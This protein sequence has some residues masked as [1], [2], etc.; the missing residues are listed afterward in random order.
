MPQ[1]FSPP[2]C[3]ATLL[4]Y[5]ADARAG[6]HIY[7]KAR[8][9]KHMDEFQSATRGKVHV[10]DPYHWMGED[11]P[12]VKERLNEFVDAQNDL[13]QKY[14]AENINMAHLE[15]AMYG[16]NM[17]AKHYAPAQYRDG[18]W[19]WFYNA[20][21]EPQTAFIRSKD[22]KLPNPSIPS[23][24][25]GEMFFDPMVL[26]EDGTASL[27]TFN[28]SDCGKYFAYGVSLS[29]GDFL[30]VFVRR[31]DCPLTKD[32]DMSNDCGRF[33]EEIKHVKF[34]D[35]MF[36]PDSKGIFYQRFPEKT[37][38]DGK[39]SPDLDAMIYYHSLG[40]DQSEDILVHSDPEN[41]GSLFY[42]SV[43]EDG[44]Y[45]VLSTVEDCGTENKLWVV[46]F[47][48]DNIGP[49]MPWIKLQDDWTTE[50]DFVCNVGTIFY[51]RTSESAP[52]NRLISIDIADKN[53][54][55]VEVIP[56]RDDAVLSKIE[57]INRHYFIATYKRNVMNELYVLT[58]TGELV[59]QVAEG[60][61]GTLTVVSLD[62]QSWFFV[63]L[64]GFTTPNTHLKYDFNAPED[65]RITVYR[66]TEIKGL[67]TEK[68][69][70]RQVWY[71]SQDGTSV[72]MFIVRHKDIPI[73]GTAAV[74]Q[75][76]YGGFSVNMDP[77]FSASL[78]TFLQN[79][80]VVL[81]VP[82][83]RG[84]GELGE[85]WHLAAI[86]ENKVKSF[87][88]YIAATKYLVENGYAA[89]GKVALTGGSN[90]GLLIAASINLAPEGTFGCAIPEVG[91]FDLLNFHRFTVGSSWS[92]DY[93]N[94]DE[95]ADF[96][97]IQ[98]IS[99]L[100]NIDESKIYPPML[101]LTADQDDRVVPTHSFKLIAELQY[102]LPDNPH[103]LL[104]RVDKSAGHGSGKSTR[105]RLSENAAKWTF[106]AQAMGLEWKN[107]DDQS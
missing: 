65:Q 26:S 93:G 42:L 45:L 81:A 34:C 30:S 47:D 103:P 29:G 28:F 85:S 67:D 95:P 20:G 12:E 96:D 86:R 107:R 33:P 76:G 73:D 74:L 88:D 68:F 53:L 10:H 62:Y 14:L 17:Y 61:V 13:V 89:P 1:I 64:E 37:D 63:T 82:N 24:I 16:S 80:G 31:T 84:G 23:E 106:V 72:P 27:V 104:L 54:T 40:T 70:A 75:Y 15:K 50:N 98:P 79:Y 21:V 105:Q 18:R 3:S 90:G 83:I 91:V 2:L 44:K 4:G 46:E 9:S 100:H 99:P 48:P 39:D 58:R 94:A 32:V 43:T 66:T 78:L 5:S 60:F 22:S 87:E 101:I 102:R 59:T 11:T 35:I 19:Y 69:E 36:S 8:R 92:S 38:E 49:N 77:W 55:R 41:R 6:P 25:E 56:E 57:S 52:R 7:P 51:L 71:D 97:F